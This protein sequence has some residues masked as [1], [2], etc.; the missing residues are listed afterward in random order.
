MEQLRY[1]PDNK[2]LQEALTKY[3]DLF[4]F[5]PTVNC[6]SLSTNYYFGF[7]YM[8]KAKTWYFGPDYDNETKLQNIK[9]IES[10]LD[11]LVDRIEITSPTTCAHDDHESFYYPRKGYVCKPKLEPGTV[12]EVVKQWSNCY[13]SYYKAKTDDGLIYDIPINKAKQLNKNIIF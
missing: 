12:L 9:E 10:I 2:V 1:W 5:G 4:V 7:L 13:G 6:K 3:P 11:Q 8:G